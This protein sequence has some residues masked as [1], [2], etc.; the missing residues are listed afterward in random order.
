MSPATVVCAKC[1]DGDEEQQLEKLDNG[2]RDSCTA[3]FH[4]DS[5]HGNNGEGAGGALGER[6]A[7]VPKEGQMVRAQAV[8]ALGAHQ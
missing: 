5:C 1:R 6:G 3:R 7:H 4:F 2:G 8:C